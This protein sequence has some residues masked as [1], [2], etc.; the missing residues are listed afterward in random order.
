[1]NRSVLIIAYGNPLRSDDGV[2]WH[3][4]ER[5]RDE[6]P[7]L[8]TEIL[9]VHQLAPELAEAASR[10]DD[11]IFLDAARNGEPGQ[12]SCT[13][14][15]SQPGTARFSHQQTPSQ[16]VSL[17]KQLYGAEPRAFLVSICGESF[18]H[19]EELS[20]TLRNALPGLVRVV[21]DL[22]DRLQIGSPE[23]AG[24]QICV[25]M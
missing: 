5:L 13:P 9:C 8:G 21:G 25:E 12:I 15:N 10:A 23:N 16:I 6:F 1:M 19:G 24:R 4:A 20:M 17:C 3:A 2:A 18:D 14:L 22:I 11:L 7:H